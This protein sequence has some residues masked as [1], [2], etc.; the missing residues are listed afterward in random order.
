MSFQIL[1]VNSFWISTDVKKSVVVIMYGVQAVKNTSRAYIIDTVD[2]RPETS[3]LRKNPL[4]CGNSVASCPVRPVSSIHPHCSANT[5]G[6]LS[7]LLPLCRAVSA[8]VLGR[9]TFH[10]KP[11]W[12]SYSSTANSFFFL[13]RHRSCPGHCFLRSAFCW[14]L[15][16]FHQRQTCFCFTF[17]S[18]LFILPVSP[19]YS[20]HPYSPSPSSF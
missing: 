16:R 20:L 18:P 11:V 12:A 2:D 14:L 6:V 3:S 13:Y 5:A 7:H 17:L 4:D 1:L 10:P 8:R 15:E 9:V 19:P